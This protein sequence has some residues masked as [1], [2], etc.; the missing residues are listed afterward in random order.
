V[1]GSLQIES[2]EG[3]GTRVTLYVP[4]GPR[5]SETNHVEAA[6]GRDIDA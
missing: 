6:I 5:A 1:A 4:F 3:R 2:A